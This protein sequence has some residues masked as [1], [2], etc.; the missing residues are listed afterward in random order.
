[1]TSKEFTKGINNYRKIVGNQ[2]GYKKSGYVS[3]KIVNGYFFYILH[4]VDASVDLKVKPLY[5]DD[6]WWDI[7]QMP[8]CKKPLSLRGNGAFALSGELIGEYQTFVDGWKNYQEQD[9]EIIWTLVFNK[10]EAEIENF[11][12]Q[13]PSADLYMP[14]ATN[15]RGDVSLTYLIA[16]LHNNKVHKV[17]EMIQEARKNG[18]HC[19][20]SQWIDDEEIDGYSFIIRYANSIL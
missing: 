1:M 3:Y 6:L 4:L 13:N 18:R 17:I 8:E 5:A 2:F 16:L 15:M 9:F 19:G 11:I 14:P 20:M 10:I 12:T 7:F